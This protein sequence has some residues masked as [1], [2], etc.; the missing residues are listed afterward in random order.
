MAR[1]KRADA[2]LRSGVL[3]PKMCPSASGRSF[4]KDSKCVLF[5]AGPMHYVFFLRFSRGRSTA[6]FELPIPASSRVSK[7]LLEKI[8]TEELANV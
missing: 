5:E 2:W 7:D 1:T 6:S 4:T 3:D 8:Q